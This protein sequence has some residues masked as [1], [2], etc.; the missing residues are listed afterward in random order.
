[1]QFCEIELRCV[2]PR[3]PHRRAQ[4]T[5]VLATTHRGLLA[6]F[7]REAAAAAK[8]V[9]SHVNAAHVLRG[10][11]KMIKLPSHPARKVVSAETGPEQSL[12]TNEVLDVR[13]SHVQHAMHKVMHV[14][15]A[16][17]GVWSS[18]NGVIHSGANNH[19]LHL[20]TKPRAMDMGNPRMPSTQSA[21]G[22]TANMVEEAY[23]KASIV[24]KQEH[25]NRSG[26]AAT[27]GSSGADMAALMHTSRSLTRLS[28]VLE[29]P[30]FK[31]SRKIFHIIAHE[32][33][34]VAKSLATREREDAS[35]LSD[36]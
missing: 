23:R 5:P 18:K 33:A 29:A 31:P 13:A 30:T 36:H 6:A 22:M 15:A 2:C 14:I 19:A 8:S 7:D 20:V 25:L 4:R 1:M 28:S 10:N 34:L 12:R 17:S 3:P 24:A 9:Q 27:K 32:L 21:S 16:Q 26:V 11:A 35:R